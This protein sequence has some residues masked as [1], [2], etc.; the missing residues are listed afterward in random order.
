MGDIDGDGDLEIFGGGRLFSPQK[1]LIARHHTGDTVVGWPVVVS[2]MECTP[3]VFDLD[4]N[5]SGEREVIIND[6]SYHLLHAYNDDGTQVPD[7]PQNTG[8]SYPNS[9]SV[10][11][12]D[13]DGDIEVAY[14]AGGYV[15]LFTVEGIEYRPYM[16]EWGT[17]FHDNWNT[18]WFHPLSPQNVSAMSSPSFIYLTWTPNTEPD[19]AG[20]NIYRSDISG[21]PYT[22]INDSIVGA[23]EYY[24]VPPDSSEYYYCI[25]AE[26]QAHTASRL[27]DEVSGHLGIGEFRVVDSNNSSLHP[28]VLCGPLLLPEGETCRVFDITG[29]VV[30]SDRIQPGIYFVEVDGKITQKVI[31]VK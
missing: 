21:G 20:Y 27:S 3:I 28:T 6:N 23:T 14:V 18:G 2:G 12:V 29:R 8:N 1:A 16:T 15:F 13:A 24:D 5:D 26:I 9:A 4:L 7:W 17:W 11:D 10:G 19:L 30:M 22:M 31:K 25:T